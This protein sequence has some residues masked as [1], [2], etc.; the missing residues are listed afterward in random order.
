FER[1]YRGEDP[2]VLATPGNG[3]GLAIVRQLVEMHNGRL[4]MQSAGKPGQ[5]S[6]FSFT[7][8]I[9]DGNGNGV[10]TNDN[11]KT[12]RP[13]PVAVY[14]IS[15]AASGPAPATSDARASDEKASVSLIPK[16]NGKTA[17]PTKPTGKNE[18]VGAQNAAPAEGAGGKTP[19]KP[20][21]KRA[22]KA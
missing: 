2:L 19:A 3:L 22:T 18:S 13:E 11:G 15:R 10:G 20:K 14:A 7:L 1:F 17:K 12:A 5:G 8:P 4:W 21:R 16:S 9:D 6:T